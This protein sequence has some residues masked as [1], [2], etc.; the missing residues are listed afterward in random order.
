[1]RKFFAIIFALLLS[2]LL[3][4]KESIGR[5]TY[6]EKDETPYDI[7]DGEKKYI[8]EK[9]PERNWVL[10]KNGDEYIIEISFVDTISSPT[11][12]NGISEYKDLV[13]KFDSDIS[14]TKITLIF[15]DFNG[16]ILC[17]AV[18]RK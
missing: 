17:S 1:M 9:D 18:Y 10:Y 5:F 16:D 13:E 14:N 2:T 15:K 3:F 6:Y 12:K 11:I 4:A 7:A 8:S